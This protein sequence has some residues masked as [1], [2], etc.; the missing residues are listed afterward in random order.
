MKTAFRALVRKD[1]QLFLV[2]R[3]ALLMS[4][5][6]P[7]AIGSFF[8]YVFGGQSN[9]QDASR[10]PVLLVDQ[11]RSV[12]STEI[13]KELATERTLEVKPSDLEDARAAVRKGSVMAAV[14][15]PPHFGEAAGAAFFGPNLKPEI[16]VMYDPSHGAERAMVQGILTGKVMQSVSKEMFGGETGRRMVKDSLEQIGRSRVLSPE[17]KKT[18]T[19]LLRSVQRLNEEAVASL[20]PPPGSLTG[21]LSVPFIQRE[22]AVTS[23]DN[24]QYNG[25][26]HAF[27]GMVVQF[28]LFLGIDFGINLLQQR[29]RGLWKRFRAAPLS[30]AVLLGSRVVSAAIISFFVIVVNFLFAG[31]ILGVRVEGSMAGFLGVSAAFALMTASFGLLVA[32][33]GKTPE[34]TRGLAIFATLLAVMLGGAWIPM[35]L[36]PQW[37]Q[38]VTLVMPTRWAVDGLEAMTW[39]GLGRSAALGPMAVLLAFALV[40]N[41]IA[42]T[43]FRWEGE[44]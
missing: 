35:F 14:V 3:R 18:L 21:G 27:A 30:P 34:A 37:L 32:T 24:I 33:L 19:D 23:R 38:K 4:F 2:D 28:L 7:I 29:Q 25:Y 43:R 5:A 39:R 20:N 17:D 26:A 22:V 41:L 15:I 16:T 13:G 42:V 36:F 40:F 10:I 31:L 44:G 6:I 1:V 8:G 12:I 11:D 9:R